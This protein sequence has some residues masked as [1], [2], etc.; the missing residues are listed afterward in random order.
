MTARRRLAPF[1]ATLVLVVVLA[2]A[3]VAAAVA[4]VPVA[5]A[6]ATGVFG[7]VVGLR[8]RGRGWP[9]RGRPV[10][11]DAV[12]LPPAVDGPSWTTT[13]DTT[14]TPSELP[15]ARRQATTA[16][17]GWDVRGEAA[18]PTLLVLTEL[19]TNAVEHAHPPLRATLRLGGDFVRVEVHDTAA[20]PPRS[21]PH[22]E[23][24]RGHGVRIVAALA[25]RHGWTPDPHGKA[26][27]ADVP[28][29][30]PD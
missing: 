3:L 13:W 12:D 16:L 18:E 27:W 26:V 24:G 30:W 29:G 11:W 2:L 14:P 9:R 25:F 6:L 28:V 4:A 22:E 20:E 23:E 1:V 10:R 17:T 15:A 7:L 5:V 19:L 8:A 21:R